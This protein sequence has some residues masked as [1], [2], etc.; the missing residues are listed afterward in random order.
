MKS[1]RCELAAYESGQMAVMLRL[2][3]TPAM[4][5]TLAKHC[6]SKRKLWCVK[7]C[8]LAARRCPSY[9]IT[10]GTGQWSRV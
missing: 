2:I 9:L 7:T 6:N 3:H 5:S 4:C 10:T 8:T 1:G